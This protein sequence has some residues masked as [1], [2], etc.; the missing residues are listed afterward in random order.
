MGYITI[1]V[2][3]DSLGVIGGN[4]SKVKVRGMFRLG[5]AAIEKKYGLMCLTRKVRSKSAPNWAQ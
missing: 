1:D 4:A 5:T 3:A 2:L